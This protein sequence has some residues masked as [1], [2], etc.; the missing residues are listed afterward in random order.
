MKNFLDLPPIWLLG[1]LFAS[2]VLGK[3]EPS[4]S[5]GAFGQWLG[6]LLIVLALVPLVWSVA[7]FRRNQT[8]IEPY[9]QPR[10]LLT[11]GPYKVSRN[12]IY[13]AFVVI[14]LG[15][16]LRQGVV[17][18]LLPVPLLFVVLDRRFAAVEEVRLLASFGAEAEAYIASTRRW[19]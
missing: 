12:P 1:T 4:L 19:L 5:F 3:L 9:Q 6:N 15:F 13:L 16:A 18:S 8:P 2:W 14:A 17:I 7:L 10:I 11:E